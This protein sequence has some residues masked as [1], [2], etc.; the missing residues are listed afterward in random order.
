MHTGHRAAA[1]HYDERSPTAAKH[2]RAECALN[3][4]ARPLLLHQSTLQTPS[5]TPQGTFS[6]PEACTPRVLSPPS[7]G[8]TSV[9]YSS[10][11]SAATFKNNVNSIMTA[12]PG[13][14]H[15]CDP[16]RGSNKPVTE[17]TWNP[18]K[19][20]GFMIT[21]YSTNLKLKIKLGLNLFRM[22]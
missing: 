10:L 17:T 2:E 9:C 22:H 21:K 19:C 7:A 15:M 16:R 13:L 4:C 18:C 3:T 6:A 1:L 12:V 11:Y 5:V 8:T 20:F 14:L